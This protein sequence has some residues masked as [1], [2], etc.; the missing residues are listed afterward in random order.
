MILLKT[1]LLG[2]I[3]QKK[4]SAVALLFQSTDGVVD[5][6]LDFLDAFFCLFQTWVGI[7]RFAYF[8]LEIVRGISNHFDGPGRHSGD[9]GQLIGP[10]KHQHRKEQKDYFS[11]ADE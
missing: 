9:F 7:R 10:K 2:A 1:L 4:K 5:G 8:R 11:G 6:V 3:C